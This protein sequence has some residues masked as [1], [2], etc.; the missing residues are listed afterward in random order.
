MTKFYLLIAAINTL[1]LV[2][3]IF[4]KLWNIHKNP[5]F[6]ALT[7]LGFGGAGFFFALSLKYEG[8]AITNILWIAISVI[9]VTI[10]GYFFFKETISVLQFIGIA[11]IMIGLVLINLK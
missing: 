6:L 8:V 10:V 4:A 9:L 7:I 11:L 3:I 5:I 1:D 2:A